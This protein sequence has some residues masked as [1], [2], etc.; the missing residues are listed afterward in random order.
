MALIPTCNPFPPNQPKF[1]GMK[2][3]KLWIATRR[4]GVCIY[5]GTSFTS[6]NEN[7]HFIRYGIHSIMEDHNGNMWFTT[8][9]NGVYCYDGNTL[10]NYTTKDGLVNNSVMSILEDKQGN[11]WFGT[12]EFGLSRFDGKTFVTFSE[13]NE[14]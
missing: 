9:K 7:E 3:G 11:L 2:S 4:H 5:D 8:D 6:F 13:Y 1:T 10:K 12:R 14:G